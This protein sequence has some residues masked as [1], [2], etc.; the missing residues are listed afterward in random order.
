MR[1]DLKYLRVGLAVRKIV[2]AG[3]AIK[4]SWRAFDRPTAGLT[5]RPTDRTFELP[6][7]W[8]FVRPTDRPSDRPHV[9]ITVRMAVGLIECPFV[10]AL[11][12]LSDRARP[13]VRV[14]FW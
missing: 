4:R 2:L 10:R 1:F 14:R 5:A 9:R 3:R 13:S 8:P 11:V 6:S 7:E 12:C